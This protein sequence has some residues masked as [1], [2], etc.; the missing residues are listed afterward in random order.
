MDMA[1]IE[2]K[3]KQSKYANEDEFYNDYKLIFE[4][5]YKYNPPLHEVHLLGKKF[6]AAFDK[7]WSKIHGGSNAVKKPHVEQSK[8][9]CKDVECIYL[10]L[11]YRCEHHSAFH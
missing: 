5:C 8:Y 6:E 7:Y 10:T 1:T 3:W 9:V 4:N 11:E 2:E